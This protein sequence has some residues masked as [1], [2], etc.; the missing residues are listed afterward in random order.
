MKM[1]DIIKIK[2]DDKLSNDITVYIGEADVTDSV[3][4]VDFVKEELLN[5]FDGES[6]QL[7]KEVRT[8]F[9]KLL[10]FVGLF[11]MFLFI[12]MG[13]FYG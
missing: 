5:G 10:I 7:D 9:A 4:A 13:V 11:V 3:Y 6:Y 8:D 2:S 1:D 12:M